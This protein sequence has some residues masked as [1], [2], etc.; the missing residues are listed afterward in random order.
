MTV[1]RTMISH[2]TSLRRSLHYS[3]VSR[4]GWYYANKPRDIPVSLVIT[5]ALQEEGS[6]RPTY[7]TRRMAAT[8]SRRLGRPVN[9]KQVQ[10]IYRK[11][12]WIVP[13]KTK[14]D[15]IRSSKKILRPTAP[16]Q[17]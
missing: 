5:Q 15:I 11:L 14:S 9:R 4:K 17:L 10:R 2:S 8:L 12:G 3:G 16:D 1:A 7:G 13:Q 6:A